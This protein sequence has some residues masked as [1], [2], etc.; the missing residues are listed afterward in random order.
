[1]LAPGFS[2]VG[3]TG[4]VYL[5]APN[6]PPGCVTVM[7]DWVTHGFTPENGYDP[8]TLPMVVNV[9]SVHLKVL[10]PDAPVVEEKPK[11]QKPKLK[12]VPDE[13]NGT[14]R[15]AVDKAVEDSDDDKPKLRLV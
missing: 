9:P 8:A 7:V 14:E 1:M 6:T 11:A 10:D 12:A 5:P 4:I 2:L 3:L 15:K 13:D